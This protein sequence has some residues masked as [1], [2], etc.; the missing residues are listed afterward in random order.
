MLGLWSKFY[1]FLK[2]IEDIQEFENVTISADVAQQIV[3]L[4]DFSGHE[5]ADKFLAEQY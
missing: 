4:G 5:K 1:E 2:Y 3:E